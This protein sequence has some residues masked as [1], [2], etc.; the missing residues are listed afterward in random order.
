MTHLADTGILLRLMEPTDPDHW[1]V[2][3]AVDAAA[4]RGHPVAFVCHA[5]YPAGRSSPMPA[6]APSLQSA[7]VASAAALRRVAGYALPPALDRRLLDLGERKDALTPV[8]RDELLAWVAF[9][10]ERSVE[11]AEAELALRQLAAVGGP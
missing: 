1:R 11:R 6:A 7:L 8:E 2:W 9:T 10:Q 3:A 5:R 4:A